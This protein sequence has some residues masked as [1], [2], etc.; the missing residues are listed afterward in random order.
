MPL[1][2]ST[3]GNLLWLHLGPIAQIYCDGVGSSL[4]ILDVFFEVRENPATSHSPISQS[5]TMGKGAMVMEKLMRAECVRNITRS[6]ELWPGRMRQLAYLK[7]R[8]DWAAR[9]GDSQ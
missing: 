6:R 2:D 1:T 3:T 7:P 9:L 4:E 5:G 8:V